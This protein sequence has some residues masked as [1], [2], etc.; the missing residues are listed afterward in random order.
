MRG[1][2]ELKL[3]ARGAVAA[4]RSNIHLVRNTAQSREYGCAET[5]IKKEWPAIEDGMGG[6]FFLES[7]VGVEKRK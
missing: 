5:R 6:S 7:M 1:C 2:Q 3:K 4:P